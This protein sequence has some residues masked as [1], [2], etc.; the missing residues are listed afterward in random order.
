MLT[1]SDTT[2][3]PTHKPSLRFI[4]TNEFGDTTDITKDL[5]TSAIDDLFWA[6]RESLA[7]CGFA[8]ETIEEWFSEN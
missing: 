1:L 8:K 7:G 3:T 2:I 5:H 6:I 4:F